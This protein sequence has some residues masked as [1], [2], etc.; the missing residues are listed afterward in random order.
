MAVSAG[1]ADKGKIFVADLLNQRVV[2]AD[3]SHD[4]EQL[5]PVK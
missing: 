1:Q 4:S 2:R 3:V 5:C